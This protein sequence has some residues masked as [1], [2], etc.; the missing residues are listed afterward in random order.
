MFWSDV[1]PLGSLKKNGYII[2]NII[3]DFDPK[4]LVPPRCKTAGEEPVPKL[5]ISGFILYVET[6]GKEPGLFLMAHKASGY[7]ETL[8]RIEGIPDELISGA[9]EENKAK[10][11]CGMYPMNQKMKEWLMKELG[12]TG[13]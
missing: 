8:A 3:W 11:Y 2:E 9:I 5:N 10:E 4:Q 7:A 1:L 12:I 13:T 6:V